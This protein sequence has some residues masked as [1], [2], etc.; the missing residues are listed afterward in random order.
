MVSGFG[1]LLNFYI[2]TYAAAGATYGERFL[3]LTCDTWTY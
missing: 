2:P 1:G 3:I